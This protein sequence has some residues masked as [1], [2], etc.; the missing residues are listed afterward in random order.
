MDMPLLLSLDVLIQVLGLDAA[1][2]DFDPSVFAPLMASIIRY[3]FAPFIETYNIE[4][5][6]FED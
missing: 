3:Q 4:E 2:P 6:F 5:L 1:G